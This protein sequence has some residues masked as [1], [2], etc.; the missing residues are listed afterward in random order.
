MS[1]IFLPKVKL[2]II[3][4]GEIATLVAGTIERAAGACAKL[5]QRF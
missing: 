1:S 4:I 2:E 3:V 5:M